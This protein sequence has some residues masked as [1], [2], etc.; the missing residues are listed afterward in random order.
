MSFNILIADDSS[1]LRKVL[2]KTI[3][4]CNIGQTDFFQANNG[5][6][7]LET[8]K[9]EWIDIVLTDLNMPIMD[10][11]TFIAQVRKNEMFQSIPIV[12]VTSETREKELSAIKDTDTQGIITKPFQ[13]E[14]I[15]RMLFQLLNVE[16]NYDSNSDTEAYDF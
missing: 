13:P 3:K 14:E 9:K 11:Y 7:A 4:M 2:I 5:A 10:G 12:V 6:E 15:K 16:E 8:L 1:S